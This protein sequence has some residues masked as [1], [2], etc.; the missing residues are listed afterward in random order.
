[1]QKVYQ[2]HNLTWI[3]L[4]APTREEVVALMEKYRFHATVAEELLRPTIRPKVE[5][6]DN[7]IYLIL[8]FPVIT[9][10]G[11]EKKTDQEVD[12]VIGKDFIITVHY[13][14][15]DSLHNFSKLFE[16]NSILDKSQMNAHGGFLFFYM[17]RGL[18]ND[19]GIELDHTTKALKEMEADLFEGKE[20]AMIQTI[21]NLHRKLLGFKDAM[22]F[23]GDALRSFEIIGKEFFGAEFSYYLRAIVGESAR[24]T[25]M[26]EGHREILKDL[27]ETNNALLNSK[28][29]DT[30]K[31][32]TVMTFIILP[33]TLIAGIFGMNTTADLLFIKSLPDFFMV[34]GIMVL[35]GI[36]MFIYFKN[37]KW[38]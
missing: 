10:H 12:F 32:L 31:K 3:D 25:S 16:V 11:K 28:T 33:L 19:L 38:F 8:H 14:L 20:E 9:P 22:R 15:I 7:S 21:S 17:I 37:K 34:L 26:I 23:H 1:M 6:Q 24:I 35:A 5:L 27:Q 2:H 36:V 30:M 29:N 18:Y 4:E 13:D